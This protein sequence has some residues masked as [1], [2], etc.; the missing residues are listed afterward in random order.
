MIKVTIEGTPREIAALVD[1]VQERREISAIRRK[2]FERLT[3]ED[4]ARMAEVEET[5]DHVYTGKEIRG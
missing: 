4:F 1:A 2:S 5:T 3:T